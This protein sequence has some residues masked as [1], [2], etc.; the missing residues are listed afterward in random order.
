MEL[1]V[2]GSRCTSDP[3]AAVET[4]SLLLCC[5]VQPPYQRLVLLYLLLHLELY[6]VLFL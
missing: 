6:L 5:L 2:V 3:F 4:F 1:L